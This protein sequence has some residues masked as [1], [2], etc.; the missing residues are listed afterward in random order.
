MSSLGSPNPLLFG[1]AK[2]YEI[3]RSLRFN[4]SDDTYLS[5]TFGTNSSNTTKTFS[6]WIKRSS[7]L[8]EYT[9]ICATTQSGNIESR[10]QFASSGAL[11]FTDRDSG[12]GSTDANFYTDAL[13]RDCSAWYHVVLIIDTTNGTAGDRI[14]IYVNGSRVT[15]LS[16]VTNPSSSYAVSFMRSSAVNFIGVG[17]ATGS[18]DFSGY[19]SEIHFLDGTIKEPSNFG[20]TD[21][22]TGAWVPIKYTGGGY[23]NN[24]FYLSL[25]DNSGTTATTLGKDSSGNGNNWTPNNFSV[26]GAATDS[27]EDTPTNNFCTMNPLAG[28][29]TVEVTPGNGNLYTALS[30]A[31]TYQVVSATQAITSGKWYWEVTVTAVGSQCNLGVTS[32]T[33]DQNDVPDAAWKNYQNNGN[34]NTATGGTNTATSSWGATYTT[35]DVIGVAV[36]M[37][38]GSI[39]FYKNGSSQ[40]AAYTDL[41]SAMPDDGWI[42]FAFGYNG[43]N[44]TWNFG[45]RAF[46][47]TAPTGHLKLCTANLPEP[48]IKK[49]T[50]YFNTVL[51]TGDDAATHAIT[52]VGFQ[53][54]LL[55][56]KRRSHTQ[57]HFLVDSVRGATTYMQA[58]TTDEDSTNATTVV[59]SLDS[60]GFTLGSYD[61]TN[62]DGKTFVSWN[63]KESASAGFD[64]VSYTGN[65]SGPRTISHGLGVKPEMIIVKNREQ[66]T[67]WIT[68]HKDISAEKFVYLNTAA[69][70]MDDA[71]AW[72]DT[73]PTS[74]VF[75]VNA[76]QQNNGDGDD[77][78]AYVFSSVKG[79]SKVGKYLGNGNANGIFIYTGF[80]PSYFLVKRSH[81]GGGQD[82]E[83]L[84]TA[85]N[86]YNPVGTRL[87]PNENYAES[88]LAA[89]DIDF[90]SNGFKIRTNSS[91][92]NSSG[93]TYIFLAFAEAPF[94]YANAR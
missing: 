24:G 33:W 54:D 3:E 82:W 70:Q 46:A 42:P 62:G 84:D 19:L 23:G 52:G 92:V 75:T 14:R 89:K 13:Y 10:L 22:D 80:K 34:K 9:T 59:K 88:A 58:N 5:R 11:K 51:Y 39:T 81:D 72:N 1:A 8:D 63:W 78:I 90:V 43:C 57:N 18:D 56:L 77:I 21:S 93:I 25:S 53:P 94:K 15:A 49:G 55:W 37:S 69:L 91:G 26:S 7:R 74:S 2:D 83:V 61:G 32:A 68:Y 35:G 30:D 85:R 64:I 45:Q 60:D 20:E 71:A 86:T 17:A 31:G 27:F 4:P 79:Y 40:G 73:E 41:A 29:K 66:V 65:G 44:L 76:D 28:R 50:D 67:N 47:H 36:D 12:D 16:S 6:C 87:I 48:T 38:A